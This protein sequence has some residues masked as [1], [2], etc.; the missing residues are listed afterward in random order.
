M[1]AFFY[2]CAEAFQYIYYSFIALKAA[3]VKPRYGDAA[4]AYR[5]CGE[6]KSFL[7]KRNDAGK[8]TQQVELS[9]SLEAPVEKG[10]TV[11]QARI[12]CGDEEIGS[13]RITAGD[14][15]G[16]MSFLK[17]FLFMLGGCFRVA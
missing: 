6:E 1:V 11:G 5:T 12:F 13:L 8:I 15:V 14:E 4:A 16:K 3:A 9:D 7:V 10:L 17:A 2:I